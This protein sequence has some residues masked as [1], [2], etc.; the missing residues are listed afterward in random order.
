M[1]KTKSQASIEY[2]F[3]IAFVSVIVI[4]ILGIA[5]IY[6]SGIKDRIKILQMNECANKLISASESVF[7][8]GKP[9]KAT[10]SCYL[11][12]S[13]KSIDIAENS[14]IIGIQLSSGVTRTAFS[15]KVPIQGNLS[16]FSGT[17]NIQISAEENFSSLSMA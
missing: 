6:S 14:L 16:A 8:N 9:A 17:R 2:L 4:A 10:V 3:V 11:P 7:Y 12:E 5:I 13:I 15:S 1:G